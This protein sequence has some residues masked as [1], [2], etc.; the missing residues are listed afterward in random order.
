MSKSIVEKNEELGQL[1]VTRSFNAPLQ[2]VWDAWTTSELLEKWWGPK[3]YDAVTHSFEFKEGGVWQYSM[4]GPEGDEHKC[5]NEYTKIEVGEYFTAADYFCDENWNRSSEMV[6]GNTWRVEFDEVDGVT[7]V[8][9]TTT[10]ESSEDMK[11]YLEMG[12]EEG[13]NIGL[14]QLQALLAE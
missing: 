8:K 11:K 14:D 2:K 12:M 13:F 4:R 7:T 1:I 10:F 3:P 9:T 6:G 5:A